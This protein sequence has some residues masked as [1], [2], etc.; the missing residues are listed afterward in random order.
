MRDEPTVFCS[1]EASSGLQAKHPRR[2]RQLGPPPQSAACCDSRDSAPRHGSKKT[3]PR[4]VQ[5]Q[6]S[7]HMA[8]RRGVLEKGNPYLPRDGLNPDPNGMSRIPGAFRRP[9]H[10]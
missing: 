7:S 9:G 2:A 10:T 8:V 6:V 3:V 5:Q 1:S 4:V